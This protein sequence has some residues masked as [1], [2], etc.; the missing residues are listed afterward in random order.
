MLTSTCAKASSEYEAVT[1]RSFSQPNFTA[2]TTVVHITAAAHMAAM[3]VPYLRECFTVL[4]ARLLAEAAISLS[5]VMVSISAFI[6]S[7]SLFIVIFSLQKL[8]QRL[9]ATGKP[10]R[11]C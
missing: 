5:V 10:C 2:D 4:S 9:S 3:T 7:F 8:F 1:N 6:I 11:H